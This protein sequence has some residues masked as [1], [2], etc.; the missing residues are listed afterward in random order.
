MGKVLSLLLTAYRLPL[1]ML[2]CQWQNT[3][4][5]ITFCL[6]SARHLSFAFCLLF[7]AFLSPSVNAQRCSAVQYDSMLA[8]RY[9]FWKLKR[10]MLEDSIQSYLSSPLRRTARTGA[11]CDR[12]RIPVVVHVVHNNSTGTIGG[13]DNANI[14]DDQIKEQ[15]RVLNEDYRRKTGT[16]GFNNNPVGA[17]TGIEFYLATIDPDGKATTGI[18]RH[19]YPQKTTFDVFSDDQLLAQISGAEKEWPTDRYLNIWLARFAN[20]YLGIAQ[21]PS[22]S[23]V[24]GLDTGTELQVRTDGVFIDFRVFG[25]GS[26]VTSRLYNLGRTTTHEIGHWLGLVHTW[27]DEN[28]GTDY[29]ADTPPCESGNQTS[30]CGPVFSNCGGVRTRNMTENYLDYSPDSC[31]NV[32]T[33]NQAERMLAV[34]EKAPRR[35]RL[36]K[37]W[38]AALPFGDQLTVEIYPN[39]AADLAYIKVIQK[40]F[41]TFDVTVYSLTGQLVSQKQYKDYPSWEVEFPTTHLPPGSYIVKVKTKDETVTQRLVITR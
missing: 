5:E 6:S 9:P 30:N 29:C 16:R 20:N 2:P 27:G 3:G 38:C 34:I 19:Y 35:A 14:S 24:E 31:M 40:T 37:Y 33:K 8:K 23:G 4:R 22:V 28:C 32:F 25:I 1:A 39:P 11:I 15:I 13:R 17:D 41:G 26:A 12:I 10:R 21:F 36:V 7:L 18:T